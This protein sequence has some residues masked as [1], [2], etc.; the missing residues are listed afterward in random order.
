VGN[1]QQEEIFG[2]QRTIKHYLTSGLFSTK[3]RKSQTG[4]NKMNV[5][6]FYGDNR[7]LCSVLDN[8]RKCCDTL[9]FAPMRGLIEEA[10][11][12]GERMEEAL[13]DKRDYKKIIKQLKND[14]IEATDANTQ[15]KLIEILKKHEH[16]I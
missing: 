8:M 12:M 4:C 16:N 13:D 5:F 9:N 11:I 6:E 2:S 3:T 7:H 1:R 10:Q 14:I 15:E